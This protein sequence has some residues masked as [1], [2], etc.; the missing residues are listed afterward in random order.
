MLMLRTIRGIR[1]VSALIATL[2]GVAAL[3]P[4]LARDQN[5][6]PTQFIAK[7]N[8]EALGRAPGQYG[9]TYWTSQFA[10]STGCNVQSLTNVATSIYSGANGYE[11]EGDY[12]L[13]SSVN[14]QARLIGLYRGVLNRDPDS[15]AYSAWLP[16]ITSESSWSSVVSQILESGEFSGL[17]NN[18]CSAVTPHYGF[19]CWQSGVSDCHLPLTPPTVQGCDSN[20]INILASSALQSALEDMARLPTLLSSIKQMAPIQ[21]ALRTNYNSWTPVTLLT[22][23]SVRLLIRPRLSARLSPRRCMQ[24][25]RFSKIQTED[26]YRFLDGQ[27]TG[28]TLCITYIKSGTS[29]W[30]QLDCSGNVTSSQQLMI[31]LGSNTEFAGEWLNFSST[32]LSI[33]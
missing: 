24:G 11:F 5:I 21:G 16:Q 20:S 28:N 15:T 29:E 7:M 8:T 30:T 13:G 18:I 10:P 31:V 22:L 23:A 3:T 4:S 1:L 19:D 32:S 26:I 17:V 33:Q 27:N 9:W 12:P 2:L 14:A 6:I 25:A